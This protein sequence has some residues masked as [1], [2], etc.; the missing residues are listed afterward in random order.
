MTQDIMANFFTFS[1]AN[2]TLQINYYPL[3]RLEYQGPEGNFVYPGASPGRNMTMQEQSF[4]G[5]QVTVVLMP[6]VAGTSVTL[7]LL[8][9]PH[10]HGGSK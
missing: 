1:D 7:T 8:L 6:S 2:G 3:A 4:L 9:P 5:Q 10:Q